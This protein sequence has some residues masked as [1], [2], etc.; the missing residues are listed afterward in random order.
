MKKELQIQNA[1]VSRRCQLTSALKKG[2]LTLKGLKCSICNFM[3]TSQK[4]LRNHTAVDCKKNCL[5]KGTVEVIITGH[6]CRKC[7]Y[8]T[9]SSKLLEGHI[10]MH[11]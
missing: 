4:L 10:S 2:V 7:Q 3:A 6:N 8:W 11:V 9:T 1:K 5:I